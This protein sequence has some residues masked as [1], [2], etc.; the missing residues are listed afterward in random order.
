MGE[1]VISRSELQRIRERVRITPVSDKEAR[2][3][4][5]KARSDNRVTKWPNTLEANRKHKENWKI[6]KEE[7]AEKERQ[8]IDRQEAEL[9]KQIRLE[10]IRKANEV[11]YQQTDRMKLLRSRMLLADVVQDREIQKQ[12]KAMKKQY[13]KE[14]EQQHH[15]EMMKQMKLAEDRELEQILKQKK[16]AKHVQQDQQEQLEE[17]KSKYIKSLMEEKEEGVRLRQKVEADFLEEA[18]RLQSA[19]SK[20]RKAAEEMLKS[21]EQFYMEKQRIKEREREYEIE[22]DNHQNERLKKAEARKALEKKR[23]DERQAQRQRMIDR[24]TAEL[25][26]QKNMEEERL[27][28]AQMDLQ[29]SED[30]REREKHEKRLKQQQLCAQSREVQAQ[31]KREKAE[32]QRLQDLQFAQR[33]RETNERMEHEEKMEQMEI[34]RQNVAVRDSQLAHIDAKKAAKKQ[35]KKDQRAADRRMLE[36]LKQDEER[37]NQIVEQEALAIEAE[38]LPTKMVKKLIGH[39]GI[40]IQPAMGD[41]L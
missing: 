13:E 34:R 5:L 40:D 29:A 35:V 9:Q 7:K 41:R 20:A 38:G 15:E 26:A 19:K 39:K 22:C 30:A 3:R 8:E 1:V 33:W 2:R 12:E 32:M 16:K 24:A 4:E 10:T 31:I 18:D 17:Y 28:K 27:I 14:L 25:E 21:N 23:F 36:I 11:L 37:F 6:E